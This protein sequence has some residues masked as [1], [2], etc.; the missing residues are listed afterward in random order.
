MW[1]L[2]AWCSRSTEA[3]A[4]RRGAVPGARL[5]ALLAAAC[6]FSTSAAAAGESPT[7]GAL[8]AE[9]AALEAQSVRERA[10]LFGALLAGG[11]AEAGYGAALFGASTADEGGPVAGSVM[12]IFGVT[13]ALIGGLALAGV[14]DDEPSPPALGPSASAPS[15]EPPPASLAALLERESDTRTIYAVNLGLDF[16]YATA[17]AMSVAASELGVSHEERWRWAGAALVTSAA[18]LMAIDLVGLLQASARER[19]LLDL[20]ARAERAQLLG[21]PASARL[22]P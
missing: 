22:G 7:S 16:A 9:L 17:G 4:L 18:Y 15:G 5:A 11:L 13:N 19:A 14:L 2:P 8:T 12:V 3:A 6:M 10:A 21:A 1:R 20:A